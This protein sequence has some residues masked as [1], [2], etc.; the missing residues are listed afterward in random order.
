L[1]TCIFIAFMMCTFQVSLIA[2]KVLVPKKPITWAEEEKLIAQYKSYLKTNSNDERPPLIPAS[3]EGQLWFVETFLKHGEKIDKEES[4]G[5]NALSAA[6]LNVQEDTVDL[7][8]K[9]GANVNIV[10]SGEMQGV[11]PII[12]AAQAGDEVILSRLIKSG[13]N[14][15]CVVPDKYHTTPL[16]T[17]L[18]HDQLGAAKILIKAGAIFKPYRFSDGSIPPKVVA[19]ACALKDEFTNTF[20]EVDC[21]AP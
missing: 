21:S 19:N 4:R 18:F 11:Q 8:I 13:A 1:K 15:N 2:Q 14:V 12:L 5:G 3:A 10:Y 17:A 7:L 16:Y 6:I 9:K 20:K